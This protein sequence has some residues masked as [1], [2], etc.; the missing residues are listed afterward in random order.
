MLF[1]SCESFTPHVVFPLVCGC[2]LELMQTLAGRYSM[3][4][5]SKHSALQPHEV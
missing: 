3:F 1:F 2:P 5:N 4:K